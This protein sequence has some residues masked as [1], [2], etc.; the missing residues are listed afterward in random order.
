VGLALW[1]GASLGLP[2]LAMALVFSSLLTTLVWGLFLTRALFGVGCMEIWTEHI[3]PWLFRVG[4]ALALSASAGPYVAGMPLWAAVAVVAAGGVVYIWWTGPLW[5][6]LPLPVRLR[7]RLERLGVVRS[8]VSLLNSR[9][10]IAPSAELTLV[11]T[12]DDAISAC[13]G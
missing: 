2:G 7:L 10:T 11:A 5:D 3:R 12:G 13:D 8:Q 1:L 6:R 4:P 9:Q